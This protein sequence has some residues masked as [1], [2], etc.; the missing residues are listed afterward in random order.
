MSGRGSI[1]TVNRTG[2]GRGRIEGVRATL[3]AD[4][5]I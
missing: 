2:N 1:E 5:S 3:V 4:G